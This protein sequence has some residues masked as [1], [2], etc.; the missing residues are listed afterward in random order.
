MYLQDFHGFLYITSQDDFP[1]AVDTLGFEPEVP[2]IIYMLSFDLV[3]AR[4]ETPP[5][6]LAFRRDFV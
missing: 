1:D 2:G 3:A 6:D 4:K 5:S